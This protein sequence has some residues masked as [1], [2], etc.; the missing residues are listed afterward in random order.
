MCDD[1]EIHLEYAPEKIVEQIV[2]LRLLASAMS[3]RCSA[4]ARSIQRNLISDHPRA[5]PI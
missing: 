4:D 2:T 1:D 5:S 3:L